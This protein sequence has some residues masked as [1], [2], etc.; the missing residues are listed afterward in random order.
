MA[1]DSPKGASAPAAEHPAYPYPFPP[2]PGT[3]PP[4][5]FTYPPPADPANPDSNGTAPAG[6]PYV[7]PY[8]PPPG[9]F[10]TF[11]PTAFAPPPHQPQASGSPS[12]RPKRNQVKMACT[13]CATA[14]KRCDDQRPCTRCQKYSL[15][16][17]CIDGQR[18]ERKKGIKRGPYRRRPK[19]GENGSVTFAEGEGAA[20]PPAEWNTSQG[21][22]PPAA[23][24]TSPTPMVLP[25]GA[26]PQPFPVPPEGYPHPFYPP[27]GLFL[28]PPPPGSEEGAAPVPYFYPY[29]P[30]GMYPPPPP[31]AVPAGAPPAADS[32]KEGEDKTDA[33]GTAN[34][35]GVNG[36]TKDANG[37]NG[38]SVE[39]EQG[40]GKK[41]DDVEDADADGDVEA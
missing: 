2:P 23:A 25:P 30:F 34:A 3:Y 32:K 9:L 31:G 16:D 15:H 11:P 39:G 10:Y 14:C 20:A 5:F 24:A 4:P 29:P 41:K 6:T 38:H 35:K 33:E 17:S 8:P 37:V 18:K 27:M 7:F 36:A 28:G 40:G 21:S 22:P 13:N 12:Y 1:N 26:V 19:D